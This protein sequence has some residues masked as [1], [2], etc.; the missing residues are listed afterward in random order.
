MTYPVSLVFYDFKFFNNLPLSSLT[1]TEV[2]VHGKSFGFDDEDGI[3]VL[4]RENLNEVYNY[5]LKQV[6]PLGLTRITENELKSIMRQTTFSSDAS[7]RSLQN[8][9][10]Y[11]L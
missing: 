9:E 1:H 3:T 10:I 5:Q 2:V 7:A 6:I 8:V 4:D 11:N